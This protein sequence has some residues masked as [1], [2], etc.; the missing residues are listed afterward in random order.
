MERINKKWILKCCCALVVVA[1]VFTCATKLNLHHPIPQNVEPQQRTHSLDHR[2]SAPTREFSFQ[3]FGGATSSEGSHSLFAATNEGT[4]DEKD[5]TPTPRKTKNVG[6]NT[7]LQRM[8]SSAEIAVSESHNGPPPPLPLRSK[9]VP[10]TPSDVRD[11][12]TFVLFL[13]FG[14]TGHSI[15]GSLLDAHPDIIIAHEYSVLKDINKE[16]TS[17]KDW[18]LLLFNRLYSNSRRSVLSGWRSEN[19]D[20]KGYTLGMAGNSW[21]GTFHQLRVIGDKSGGMTAKVHARDST[22]CKR[23]VEQL[24]S[25]LGVPVEAIHVVRNP[26]DT[27]ATSVLLDKGG[28]RGLVKAKNSSQ[29]DNYNYTAKVTGTYVKNF[30]E[31]TF[32][33]H[34]VT[35]QCPISVHTIHLVDLIHK[36]RSIMRELCDAVHVECYSDYLDMCEEKVFKS[37]SKTRNLVEWSQRHI[38]TVANLIKRYPEF[39]RYSF[40]CDC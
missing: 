17:N 32:L 16:F 3:T 12:R 31:A 1:V 20:R 5:A 26:Y 34:R 22:R 25:S 36:P 39:S 6:E 7:S 28:A 38:E 8:K 14:R 30:M 37:L 11:L 9:F 40:D 15:V 2:P 10:L 35:H 13:G 27:I 23:L 33:A 29:A 21:Q 24:N 18:L 4:N 19:M